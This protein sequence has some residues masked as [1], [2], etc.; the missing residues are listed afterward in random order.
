MKRLIYLVLIAGLAIILSSCATTP[1]KPPTMPIKEIY[2]AL[3]PSVLRQDVFHVVAPGET[4]WRISKMYDVPIKDLSFANNLKTE[5]LEKGQRLLI[6]NAAPIVPVIP[7]YPSKKWKYIVIHHSA[8][9]EGSSLDFDKFHQGKG[10]E[11]IGYH[12]VIDNG[13]KEKQDGQIEVSP[14]WLK[15]EN[16]SHCKAGDMNERAIG[17]CLVG[18]FNKERLSDKQMGSLVYLVNLLKR[19]YRIP[20]RNILGHGQ[21]RG[22]KTECPGR[23]FPWGQFKKQLK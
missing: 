11:G 13:T 4:L 18:N 5:T 10:W 7:L 16:G 9:D 3:A 19:Q 2:P 22:A 15:Q 8:T 6:P 14:R 17:I 20:V 23:N 1:V 21:V 12:F